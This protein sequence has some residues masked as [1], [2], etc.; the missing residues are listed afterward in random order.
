MTD[1]P[2]ACWRPARAFAGCNRWGATASRS[3]WSGRRARLFGAADR[4]GANTPL[5]QL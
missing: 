3:P 4:R 2:C 5:V 1:G